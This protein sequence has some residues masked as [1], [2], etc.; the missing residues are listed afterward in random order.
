MPD[1]IP[2]D[3]YKEFIGL[4]IAGLTAI[5][6]LAAAWMKRPGRPP[7]KPRTTNGKIAALE[8]KIAVLQVKAEKRDE[9]EQKEQWIQEAV[10]RF[11]GEQD[12][13]YQKILEAVEDIRKGCPR[14][15]T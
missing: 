9:E 11:H 8:E 14:R 5:G 13:R 6:A 12:D 15:D 2:P 10:R 1:W 4:V 3:M 7:K